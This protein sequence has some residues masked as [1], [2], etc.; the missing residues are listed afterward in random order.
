MQLTLP[1]A[2]KIFDGAV[3]LGKRSGKR[4]MQEITKKEKKPPKKKKICMQPSRLPMKCWHA[5]LRYCSVDFI[6]PMVV[7]IVR[8]WQVRL[9]FASLSRLRCH[10]AA[11]RETGGEYAPPLMICA[12]FQKSFQNSD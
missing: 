11:A 3:I 9:P 4:K 7:N 2:V 1:Y 12:L 6:Q 8:T 5:E 10:L